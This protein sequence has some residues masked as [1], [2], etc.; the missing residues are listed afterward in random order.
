MGVKVREERCW[1]RPTAANMLPWM[2]GVEKWWRVEVK[3]REGGCE[4]NDAIGTVG[5]VCSARPADS[6]VRSRKILYYIIS[7]SLQGG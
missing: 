7:S 4:S 1:C 5:L 2:I 3:E 6:K